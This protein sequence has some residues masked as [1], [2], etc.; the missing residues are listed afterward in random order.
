MQHL[1]NR[2]RKARKRFFRS[3]SEQHKANLRVIE[4]EY[5]SLHAHC[6]R[7]YIHRLE[8]NIKHDPATFWRF[9]KDRKQV[10]GIPRRVS[11]NDNVAE[12]PFESANLFSSF[13][14][15]VQSNNQQPPSEAYLNSLPRFDLALPLLNFSLQ[16]VMSKL[17]SI[18]GSKGAG[19]DNMP[20]LL[21]KNCAESLAV[22]AMTIFNRSLSEGIFRRFGSQQ[23]SRPFTKQGAHTT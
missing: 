4:S 7:C 18:D 21:L 5:N 15:S 16:D 6:F 14:R 11:Y 9:V 1:R 13:F 2:L 3:R 10:S 23:R 20:P 17:Q 19:P 22:P 12:S 8:D